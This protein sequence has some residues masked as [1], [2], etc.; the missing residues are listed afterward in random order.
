MDKKALAALESVRNSPCYPG[1]MRNLDE[2]EE[3]DRF[4]VIYE[5]ARIETMISELA[6]I[7]S[8]PVLTH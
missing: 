7:D 6:E 5:I 2:L 8:R 3:E 4:S 1:V